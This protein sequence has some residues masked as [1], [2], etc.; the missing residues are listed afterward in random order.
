MMMATHESKSEHRFPPEPRD[1]DVAMVVAESPS[2]Q[3]F[4]QWM[5]AALE[6]LVARWIHSAAPKASRVS[7]QRSSKQL[8]S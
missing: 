8:G 3:E 4:D 6:L 1:E 5:D 2:Y 7:L